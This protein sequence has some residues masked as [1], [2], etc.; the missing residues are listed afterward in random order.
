MNRKIKILYIISEVV[1]GS[2]LRR[3]C[4]LV[5]GLD[6]S[7]F[8]ISIANVTGYS[9]AKNEI[10]NLDVPYYNLNIHPPRKVHFGKVMEFSKSPFILLG[11]DYDLVH[12]LC[13]Q[14][15][16]VEALMI[17]LFT[18]AKYIYTKTN[19][20]WEN[21]ALNWSLKSSLA[22]KIISISHATDELLIKKGYSAKMVKI[23]SG[24]NTEIFLDSY[25]HRC[26]VRKKLGV[27]QDTVVFGCAAQFIEGK[28]H[29]FI[30][31][32]F[33]ELCRRYTD[34][35]LLMCGLNYNDAYYN[36]IVEKINES[37]TLRN[38]VHLLGVVND[39]PSFYSAIDCFV[40]PSINEAFGY[41]YI[42]AMSCS[43]PVIAYKG[44]GPLDIVSHDKSGFLIGNNI[45]QELFEK[46]SIY[47]EN[48]TLMNMHGEEARKR[49]ESK[50]SV[51]RMIT[52]HQKLYSH[53]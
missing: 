17:R 28:N 11:K 38:K 40:L 52:D 53:A 31:D 43:K 34:I 5:N 39:M 45:S 16:F 50:F 12:S 27:S 47:I 41:V 22:D 4:D 26:E 44:A 2:K 25:A 32:A 7:V 10:A 30:V 20:E 21:H 18:S 51:G 1:L 6:R 49:V 42:E 15:I 9:V 33:K 29:N 36:D 3:L 48:K 23:P 24:I 35:C 37:E 19:I 46:M 8:E 13:Y 14:S